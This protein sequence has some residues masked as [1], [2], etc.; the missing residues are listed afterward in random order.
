MSFRALDPVIDFVGIH[1]WYTVGPWS[2]MWHGLLS[3]RSGTFWRTYICSI[4]ISEGF[5]LGWVGG[6]GGGGGILD[7]V[8]DSTIVLG[9]TDSDVLVRFSFHIVWRSVILPLLF[10]DLSGFCGWDFGLPWD[11]SG[12]GCCLVLVHDTLNLRY[13]TLCLP[14]RLN[15]QKTDRKAL[16]CR[17]VMPRCLQSYICFDFKCCQSIVQLLQFDIQFWRKVSKLFRYRFSEC[18]ET[19]LQ[20]QYICCHIC[21]HHSTT[22]Q[23]Y[24]SFFLFQ[25]TYRKTFTH[26]S[27]NLFMHGVHW[28]MLPPIFSSQSSIHCFSP[29]VLVSWGSLVSVF[30]FEVPADFLLPVFFFLFC[31][32][33][34][35]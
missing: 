11:F 25:R 34:L 4:C 6:T 17:T 10:C 18:S 28:V 13:Y 24:H 3:S 19:M 20:Y 2:G 33:S 21:I 12:W 29:L 9:C 26:V 7:W 31:F 32:F 22:I 23:Q 15:N 16:W 5:R 27:W 1:F 14:I 8:E 35:F 30:P